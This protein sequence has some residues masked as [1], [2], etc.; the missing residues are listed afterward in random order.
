VLVDDDGN[1]PTETE[2][3]QIANSLNRFHDDFAIHQTDAQRFL[4]LGNMVLEQLTIKKQFEKFVNQ[5]SGKGGAKE[6]VDWEPIIK[7][8]V[9]N[10]HEL[11]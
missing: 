9:S 1:H 5:R 3:T 2:L 4:L 8:I 7:Q 10:T 11:I 6:T